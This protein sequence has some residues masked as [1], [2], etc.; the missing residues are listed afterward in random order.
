MEQQTISIA[1]AGITTTLN[2]RAAVLAA[3][4]PL[5]GRYN[6]KKSISDNVDL[7][8][9]LLSR[10][11]LLFLILDKADME[12]D[13]A[14]SK[15]VLHVH[16]YLK[17]PKQLSAPLPPEVFKQFIAA[18]RTL[19]PW[20]PKELTTYIVEAYVNLRLQDNNSAGS[21]GFRAGS[22]TNQAVMTARQLLSILRLS[23]ALARLR[24]AYSISHGDVDEAIRLTHSS[25]ASLM[26]DGRATGVAAED[27]LSSI[28]SII[29]DFGASHNTDVV[30]FVQ[31]ESMVV[32]KGYTPQ[33]LHSCLDEYSAL[34]VIR[35][36][37]DKAHIY[38][39]G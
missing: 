9:S 24:L 38:I 23:Q 5:Y 13:S 36:D 6:L 17:T 19:T 31:I 33:Q 21:V 15:H 28:F 14:L 16:R 26:D 27:V 20:V 2:A 30:S 8:N 29:R 1:K 18:A 25:K 35:V 39:E 11:D 12:K 4:N 37:T 10:F 22:S 34:G 3:A 32:R 7:P